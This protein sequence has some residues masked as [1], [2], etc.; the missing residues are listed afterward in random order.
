MRENDKTGGSKVKKCGFGDTAANSPR[1]A[2]TNEK[3]GEAVSAENSRAAPR[4]PKAEAAS[5][6]INPLDRSNMGGG[7]M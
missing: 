4:R 3:R 6:F 5:F 7:K 2:E 1:E